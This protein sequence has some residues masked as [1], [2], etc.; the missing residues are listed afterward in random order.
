MFFTCI[1][2]SGARHPVPLRNSR[3]PTAGK[4]IPE[5]LCGKNKTIEKQCIVMPFSGEA[6]SDGIAWTAPNPAAGQ[7]SGT[8]RH[9]AP[10]W[11]NRFSPVPEHPRQACAGKPSPDRKTG[12]PRKQAP[13]SAFSTSFSTPLSTNLSTGKGVKHRPSCQRV[14]I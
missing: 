5:S 10:D 11:R 9:P 1:C 14:K 8:N 12:K 7:S 6:Q 13:G 4:T 2:K 3:E